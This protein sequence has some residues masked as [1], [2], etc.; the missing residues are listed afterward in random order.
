MSAKISSISR[1]L[2]RE[3]DVAL[4]GRGE[5]T[6]VVETRELVGERE[7]V[8]R[9]LE[10]LT[11]GDVEHAAD[12]RRRALVFRPDA[13]DIDR[14]PLAV[15]LDPADVVLD[16]RNLAADALAQPR[17]RITVGYTARNAT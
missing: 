10:P 14:D 6:P 4:A 5:A 13:A 16:G 17:T 9:I 11:I 7:R 3:L 8:Q 1:P 15:L 2:R 12:D